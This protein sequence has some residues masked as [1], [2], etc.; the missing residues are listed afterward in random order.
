MASE[1]AVM[2]LKQR[3][4]TRNSGREVCF[5]ETEELELVTFHDVF[6]M[7]AEGFRG[8]GKLGV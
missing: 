8:A 4:V 7:H 6:G 5:T 3:G 1:S 2:T